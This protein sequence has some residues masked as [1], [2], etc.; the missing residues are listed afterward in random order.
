MAKIPFQTQQAVGVA[1]PQ[2]PRMSAEAAQ[3][4]YKA[5]AGVGQAVTGVGKQV[6]QA[7][8]RR[9]AIEAEKGRVESDL[10]EKEINGKIAVANAT[11]KGG[12]PSRNDYDIVGTDADDGLNELYELRDSYL[13]DPRLDKY[14]ELRAKLDVT[15]GVDVELSGVAGRSRGLVALKDVNKAT[16]DT[17]VQL[18]VDSGDYA[19]ARTIIVDSVGTSYDQIEADKAIVDL[20]N[21]HSYNLVMSAYALDP[22]QTIKDL[23]EGE[24]DSFSYIDENGESV[25]VKS[26]I[27]DDYKRQLTGQL[28]TQYNNTTSSNAS[29]ITDRLNA[30]VAGRPEEGDSIVQI[31]ADLAKMD[32]SNTVT[33]A[34]FQTL[35]ARVADPFGTKVNQNL[36][37][38]ELSALSTLFSSYDVSQDPTRSKL[39]EMRS[40]LNAVTNPADR[41]WLKTILDDSENGIPQS[42]HYKDIQKQIDS[43]A[44]TQNLFGEPIEGVIS[45]DTAVL[46]K[47]SVARHLRKNPNDGKGAWDLYDNI[48]QLDKEG[49]IDDYYQRKYTAKQGAGKTVVRTG[50]TKDGRSV[51]KYS[52]GSIEYGE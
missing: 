17:N 23:N 10:L 4:P 12:L 5:L 44:R 43:D 41:S 9:N 36:P 45:K 3:A 7:V 24:F 38:S 21:K 51:T 42:P 20:N 28:K 39:A 16:T 8:V 33:P 2:N 31:Q 40:T 47:S 29:S 27:S 6:G 13:N 37:A 46:A 1:T 48:V 26:G 18:L 11:Y 34:D 30:V 50:K 22:S 52:D 19:G 15:T 35:N 32:V 49:A 14:P 25:K